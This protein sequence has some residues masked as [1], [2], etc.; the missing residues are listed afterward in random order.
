MVVKIK[1]NNIIKRKLKFEDYENFLEATQIKNKINHQKMKF[2]Q[3]I[4]KKD[5]R[6]FIKSNA[7]ILKTQQ[8]FNS[9]RQNVFTEEINKVAL[10][11]MMVK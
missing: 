1:K 6:E 10:V 5:Q 3:I 11:Q 8:R 2:R 9:F 7:L 4:L